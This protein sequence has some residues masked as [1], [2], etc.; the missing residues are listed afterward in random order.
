MKFRYTLVV[1]YSAVV[2]TELKYQMHAMVEAPPKVSELINFQNEGSG[3]Y[4]CNHTL[5]ASADW[6]GDL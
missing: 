2:F 3:R 5:S 6:K 4:D 1:S